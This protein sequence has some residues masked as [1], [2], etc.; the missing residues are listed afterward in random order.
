V[1]AFLCLPI[2]W[3]NTSGENI[4]YG[5][6]QE[7]LEVEY[8]ENGLTDPTAIACFVNNGTTAFFTVTQKS[9]AR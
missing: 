9:A 4:L 5:T 3:V 2:N 8:L 1:V 7:V 6:V